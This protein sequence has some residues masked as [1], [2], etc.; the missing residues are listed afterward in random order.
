[1]LAHPIGTVPLSRNVGIN[2]DV[3]GSGNDQVGRA[4]LSAEIARAYLDQQPA[5]KLVSVSYIAGTDPATLQ[6]SVI[7]EDK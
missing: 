4:L 6:P 3:I 5:V 7:S 1:M 2:Y